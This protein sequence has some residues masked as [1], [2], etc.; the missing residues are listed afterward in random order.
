MIELLNVSVCYSDGKEAISGVNLNINDNESV[1]IIGSNGAGKSTLLLS[2][3]GALPLAQGKILVNKVEVKKNNL[4]EILSKVGFVFQ[5]PDDQLFM[6]TIYEDI[7]FG[8]VNQN[9]DKLEI[10]NEV[11]KILK[12]LNAESLINKMSHK[13]SG[14][15]KRVAAIASVLVMKPSIILLDEPS[16]YLDPRA[17][18]NLI[19]ILNKINITKI[20]ATHDLDMALDLC[21]RVIII[22][23]GRIFQEGESEYILKDEELLTKSGLELPL[24]FS[25]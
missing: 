9:R 10:K 5:N 4:S 2:M 23:E 12:E 15:E 20:I 24:R 18:K 21:K 19:S 3:I 8:L 11:E 14:G 22:K 6:P 17:R 7:A 1:A 13:L 16:A 25:N